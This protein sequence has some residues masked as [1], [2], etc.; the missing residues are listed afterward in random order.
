MFVPPIAC[1]T[2]ALWN[3]VGAPVAAG[4]IGQRVP[5]TWHNTTVAST[6]ADRIRGQC[7]RS[8]RMSIS[9]RLMTASYK[10]GAQNT[11]RLIHYKH[12]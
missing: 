12:L 11:N 2:W 6:T 8:D 3:E 5:I 10:P 7:L 4:A 1:P 9:I